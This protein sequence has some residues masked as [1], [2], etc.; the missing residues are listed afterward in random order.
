MAWRHAITLAVSLVV[1]AGLAPGTVPARRP[2]Q[3]AGSTAERPRANRPGLPSPMMATD[4]TTKTDSPAPKTAPKTQSAPE[5][6]GAPALDLAGLE[7]RLRDTKAIGVFTKLTLKN[8]VEDLLE[9]IKSFHEGRGGATLGE[10]RERYN[11]LMLKVL[12]LLQ[13][14]DP[15]LARDLSASREALWNILA[16]PVKFARMARGGEAR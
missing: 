4:R 2:A 5:T 15:R 1:G 14:D 6:I 8:Q 7:K 10:L 11:L 3:A 16:D 12:S 13:R 9:Q